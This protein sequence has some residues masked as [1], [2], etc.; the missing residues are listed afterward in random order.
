MKVLIIGSGFAGYS[1]AREL[2]QLDKQAEIVIIT[3]DDGCFY[4]K[5][6]LSKA[7]TDKKTPEMLAMKSAAQF[8]EE[9]NADILNHAEVTTI[10]T[11]SQQVFYHNDSGEHQQHYDKL[12]LACGAETLKVPLNGDATEQV[13]QVNNLEDYRQFRTEIENKK[14]ITLIGAGLIGCEF[15]NDLSN[16][17]YQI[18]VI[19]LDQWPL[20]KLLPQAIGQVLQQALEKNGVRFHLSVEVSTIN[21]QEQQLS[22]QLSNGESIQ[23]DVALAA[24]GLKPMTK[25]AEKA[26]IAIKRGIV[27]DQYLQTSAENVYAIG[28]CAEVCDIIRQHIAPIRFSAA[29]LAATLAGNPSKIHY[30][31]MAVGVKTPSYPLVICPPIFDQN[32]QWQIDIN[33]D[34]SVKAL[35]YDADQ[36]LNGFILGG[37]TV[38]E[39]SALEKQI[40]AWLA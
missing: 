23:T 2:R 38:A 6:F 40:A 7:M 4:S 10:N 27:T 35:H 20:P 24:I 14:H 5:P 22:I 19:S 33:D 16:V 34:N 18:D 39:R 32:G 8:S 31:A 29:S 36:Q 25:L 15:A 28:D 30:P 26:G 9:L 1:V 17:D 12:V 11:Q 3:Q 37:K 13:Y 21:H